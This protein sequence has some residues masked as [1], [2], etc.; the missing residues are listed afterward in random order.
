MM[1]K[2]NNLV[3]WRD[4]PAIIKHKMEHIRK[5][6]GKLFSGFILDNG[7]VPIGQ[8]NSITKKFEPCVNTRG[9]AYATRKRLKFK[10]NKK[11]LSGNGR[12]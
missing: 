9:I 12:P 7:D 4:T 2:N 11:A 6:G 5:L 3:I 10:K 8:F 1:Q